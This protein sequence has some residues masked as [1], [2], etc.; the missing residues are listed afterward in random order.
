MP[1][2]VVTQQKKAMTHAVYSNFRICGL[3]C[4]TLLRCKDEPKEGPK[5]IG[6]LHSAFPMLCLC[7]VLQLELAQVSELYGAVFFATSLHDVYLFS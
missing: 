6:R 3:K 7:Y 2:I 5:Q 1:S 4:S